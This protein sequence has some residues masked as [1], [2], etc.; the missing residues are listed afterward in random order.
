MSRICTGNLL[1]FFFPTTNFNIVI[2]T[3]LL[4]LKPKNKK[5][6][7]IKACPPVQNFWTGLSKIHPIK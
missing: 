7:S 2:V 6:K 5:K 3:D 1:T 4:K